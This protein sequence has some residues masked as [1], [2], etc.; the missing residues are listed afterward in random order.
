LLDDLLTDSSGRPEYRDLHQCLLKLCATRYPSLPPTPLRL[1]QSG[2][3]WTRDRSRIPVFSQVPGVAVA[4]LAS[5]PTLH[6]FANR[7]DY[8]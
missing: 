1:S 2:I 3:I 4:F 8:P 7:D 5:S 6:H